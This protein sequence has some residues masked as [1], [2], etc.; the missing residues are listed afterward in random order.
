MPTETAGPLFTEHAQEKDLLSNKTTVH[1]R[2][3]EENRTLRH[4]IFADNEKS[5]SFD[6]VSTG[7]DSH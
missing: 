7:F 5:A 3:C 6:L 2:T 4:G 1:R